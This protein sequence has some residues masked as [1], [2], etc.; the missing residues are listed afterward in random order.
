M[1]RTNRTDMEATIRILEAVNADEAIRPNRSIIGDYI[2]VVNNI[3]R[4]DNPEDKLQVKEKD[5]LLKAMDA[6]S[7]RLLGENINS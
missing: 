2:G 6:F 1:M 3:L 5:L 4:W 7:E